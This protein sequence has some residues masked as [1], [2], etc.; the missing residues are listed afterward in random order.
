MLNMTNLRHY[1]AP[2][3]A[4]LATA[5]SI[6]SVTIGQAP[7][8][9]AEP[10]NTLSAA[11]KKA[12]WTLLFDGKTLNGWR[13]YKKTD[14]TGTRWKVED[15][16]LT[17]DPGAG[18]DTHGQ[19]DIV[20]TSTFERF[21][22]TWEWRIAEGGNSGLK[23]FVLEDQNSAIG[24]EYQL[25]DD[26]RHPDAKI[27][28]H[29]QTAAL[30]DVLAAQNR[31]LKPAGQFNQ[32]RIVSNGTTVE[33][34]LNGT[35]V[36]QYELDSPALRAAI[37]KSKF[38]DIAR[39]GKLQDG[40]ILLQDHGDR[41][42][43]RNIKIKRL[44]PTAKGTQAAAKG[45]SIVADAAGKR[46]DVTI[47]GK[48]FTSYIY[49]DTL[50]KPTL[51]PIRTSSG[52]LVT[53]GFPLEPRP[54]ERFDHPHHVGL[55]FNHGDVN[56]L[57]FW[58]NS[59]D[60]PADRAP[61]MGTIHHKRV[62]ET[63]SGADR[64][65]LA[66]ETEWVNF[67]NKPLLR[68]T[69]RYVFRGS[70]DVRSIDRITT[71][72]ALDQKVVF[73]DNKEGS[74]GLRVAR[75]LEQPADK[76]ELFTDASGKATSVPVLDNTGVTGMYTSSEGL[77]GDEVWGTRGRWCMLSGKIGSEAVTIAMLDHPS[78][79]NSPTY[80]H[81]RGYG[82]FS[83]NVFGRKV[84]DSTQEELVLTLEPGKSVTFRHRV[85]IL[86]SAATAEAIEREYK[87]FAAAASSSR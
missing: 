74:L 17:V 16:L 61:K 67:E 30:Y 77:K 51:F 68:E 52:T 7:A 25:I 20:T 33:H 82:L 62:I 18:N 29:R 83:A 40:F 36:L 80:W 23:Y 59:Y 84:F 69:A 63:K 76:P 19:M 78:N 2:A 42:W 64:G 6:A 21:E 53:R 43:Y 12:G 31:P 5:A 37:A 27:G 13:A 81:A 85:L 60:I 66:V 55:W 54:R 87:T 10:A 47:D 34:Y 44:P 32:S 9:G 11:E 35:K 45:I 4:A 39:F 57:D 70:G 79:P 72:T 71:L 50:K 38:K 1:I 73:R 58:N 22:L 56:G 75:E 15:G 86:D 48:P 8:K 41:V 3:V 24:H 46:V 14:A 49:P 65:E 28:P 26:E